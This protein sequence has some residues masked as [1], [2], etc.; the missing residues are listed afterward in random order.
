M[1][2]GS[3]HP[4][5]L[6]LALDEALDHNVQL[7]HEQDMADAGFMIRH[8][9]ISETQLIKAF[10]QMKPIELVELRDAFVR[11]RPIIMNLARDISPQ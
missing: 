2:A 6:L 8:D 7:I 11:A 9:R 3:A 1:S 10:S 4:E 5:R